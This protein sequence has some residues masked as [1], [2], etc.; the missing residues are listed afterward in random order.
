[1]EYIDIDENITKLLS[2]PESDDNK[3]MFVNKQQTSKKITEPT[4][5]GPT[6]SIGMEV[7]KDELSILKLIFMHEETTV[8]E[9]KDSLVS[10]YLS[11]RKYMDTSRRYINIQDGGGEGIHTRIVFERTRGGIPIAYTIAA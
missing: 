11:S 4:K 3:P 9:N 10:S 7:D 8:E 6:L 5:K 2:F 1:M